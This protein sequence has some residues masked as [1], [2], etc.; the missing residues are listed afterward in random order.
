MPFL[1]IGK[2]EGTVCYKTDHEDPG[3]DQR[4]SS[5]SCLTSVLDGGLV[6][7]T[8]LRPLYSLERP[9]NL[10]VGGWECPGSVWTSAENLALI[11]IRFTELPVRSESLYR[12]R[13]PGPLSQNRELIKT[14]HYTWYM[15]VKYHIK[16]KAKNIH[17][18]KLHKNVLRGI[19]CNEAEESIG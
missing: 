11:R 19:T 6:V 13:Y 5:T 2:G 9:N 18:L 12:L 14:K 8:T 17:V 15:I 4:Y 16:H 3:E 10:C 7:N 1:T